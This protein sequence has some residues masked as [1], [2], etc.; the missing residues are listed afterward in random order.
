MTEP[1]P[2][3]VVHA[4]KAGFAVYQLSLCLY[5]GTLLLPE[6]SFLANYFTPGG[7]GRL[8]SCVTAIWILSGI[9][10]LAWAVAC[11]RIVYAEGWRRYWTYQSAMLFLFLVFVLPAFMLIMKFA[12]PIF[13]NY[14]QDVNYQLHDLMGRYRENVALIKYGGITVAVLAAACVAA[15]PILLRG[16]WPGGIKKYYI[17]S[18]LLYLA[19]M[20]CGLIMLSRWDDQ[21]ARLKSELQQLGV[22]INIAQ[23][24]AKYGRVLPPPEEMALEQEYYA[25]LTTRSEL[26]DLLTEISF[27]RNALPEEQNPE[28][29]EDILQRY[30]AKINL[31]D[32]TV[33]LNELIFSSHQRSGNF[34]HTTGS[35][36][37]F[38][39]ELFNFYH[40][41]MQR[42]LEQ[43]NSASAADSLL[44]MCHIIAATGQGAGELRQLVPE[45]ITLLCA[46]VRDVVDA[47][48][49][50]ASEISAVIAK[51]S[52]LQAQLPQFL[53]AEFYDLGASFDR[54]E[55][56]IYY[57]FSLN[58]PEMAERRDLY[59]NLV[60]APIY[61][62]FMRRYRD[63]LQSYLKLVKKYEA[64]DFNFS[65]LPEDLKNYQENNHTQ[66]FVPRNFAS[67]VGKFA[68]EW[69]N[70]RL[71]NAE[72][73]AILQL[74]RN[75]KK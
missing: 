13:I 59:R 75:T 68:A 8:L 58:N 33:A 27:Y 74:C 47:K 53:K 42:A 54:Y 69:E 20:G 1:V 32:Q 23:L 19:A 71:A 21:V 49:L 6:C 17:F 67:Q 38:P 3:R 24:K 11:D 30:A 41:L 9:Y 66:R 51:L 26:H 22:P 28:E 60:T 36:T 12:L 57:G 56:L 16:I 64:T 34:Y 63:E 46:A 70:M 4:V 61:G 14:R 44:K 52:Q 48:L 35:E 40:L 55:F 73:T 7:V 25:G 2:E 65:E 15:V 37:L 18:L 31:L 43:K 29:L 10:F 50:N 5:I 45:Q 72:L 39:E 62:I